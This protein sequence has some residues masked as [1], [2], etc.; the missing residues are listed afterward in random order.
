MKTI[1]FF[2]NKGGVGKTTL[3]HHLAWMFRELGVAVLLMDLDPQANLTSAF[4]EDDEI[5]PLI[6]ADPP[7]TILGAV[8]PL[9]DRLGD[10]VPAESIPITEGIH[11]IAGDPG[12]ADFED[13]L[14]DAWAKCLDDNR[15]NRAD[16]Q[17]VTTAFHRI[18]EDAAR[19][20]GASLVLLDLGPALSPLNRSALVAADHV[21]VPV[22]ADLFSLRGMLNLGP[23][24]RE[25]RSGW[26]TRRNGDVKLPAGAMEPVGYVVLAHAMRHGRPVRAYERW[27]EQIPLAFARHVRG[28]ESPAPRSAETDP[29][30]LATL[31]NYMSLMPLAQEARKPVFA[32][33]ARDGAL[34][35]H[36]VA[37]S[38]AYT[39]FEQLARRIAQSCGVPLRSRP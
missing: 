24:L 2:N 28:E 33:T 30:R 23:R 34:G 11:L 6:D 37:V 35:A 32:L 39:E 1:A 8:R 10:V 18:A 4:L 20:S 26:Q 3:V 14:S 21:V 9:L 27:I 16:G 12:L 7:R 19:R 31:R 29:Y 17:R 15:P 25:W 5:E 36:G 38:R 22:G 13:R